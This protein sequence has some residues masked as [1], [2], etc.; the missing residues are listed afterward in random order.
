M[1]CILGG[2]YC[3]QKSV[4]I[5]KIGRWL[6][7]PACASR[8]STIKGEDAKMTVDAVLTRMPS[9]GSHACDAALFP[10]LC[11]PH[12]SPPLFQL[13]CV[14]MCDVHVFLLGARLRWGCVCGAWLG[15]SGPLIHVAAESA[16]YG[17]VEH[18]GPCSISS[19]CLMT[20]MINHQAVRDFTVEPL[21]VA[22]RSIARSRRLTNTPLTTAT[23]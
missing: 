10:S 14:C 22:L 23:T 5:A 12:L 18:C 6:L 9:P 4:V 2:Q 3:W 8:I 20:C 19:V 15:E 11:L 17:S 21:H 1:N 16:T 13:A 7:Q